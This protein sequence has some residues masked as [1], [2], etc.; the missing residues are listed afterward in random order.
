MTRTA[1]ILAGHGSHISPNTAGVVWRYADMLRRRG[2]ADEV[3]ACFWKEQPSLREALMTVL[4]DDITVI[5]VFTAQGY[6][7]QSVIPAEMGLQGAVT[8]ANGRTIRY[9]RTPGEHPDLAE[10]VHKRVADRLQSAGLQPDQTTVALVGHGTRRNKDSR[11]ATRQQAATLAELGIVREVI[12]A[13]LDDDPSI[14]SIY[15]R[16]ATDDVIVVPFFLAPGSH[17]TID[18]PDALGLP[19]GTTQATLNGKTIHYTDPIGTDETLCNMI[20]DLAHEAGMPE[21]TAGPHT[22]WTGFPAAGADDLIARIRDEGEVTVGELRLTAESVE[23]VAVSAYPTEVDTPENLRSQVRDDP[24][25]MLASS[26]DLPRNWRVPVE[27]VDTIPAVVETVYPG[28][29]A[30]LARYRSGALRITP[31]EETIARQQG[32]FRELADLSFIT[33]DQAVDALCSGVCV[34]HPLWHEAPYDNEEIVPCG[35]ACNMWL[36]I[37]LEGLG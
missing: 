25:R 6:F 24:F 27:S 20:I 17:V 31:L 1:L 37:A 26:E 32:D 21:R 15:T 34:K 12:D 22:A 30:A 35:E 11:A 5:P 14:P 29:V 7:T 2:V 19:R 10:I 3:T 33:I 23:P 8:Q 4:A 28:V 13:Y 18:V 16:A 36:S 9:G